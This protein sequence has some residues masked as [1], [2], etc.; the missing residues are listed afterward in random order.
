[1]PAYA[2]FHITIKDAGPYA[3]YA[4]HTPRVIAQYGGKMLVR[5]G[6]PEVVE[7][8]SPGQR[9]VVLE[10]A[11]R[12]AFKTFYNSPEYQKIIGIRQAVSEGVGMVVD[13]F[14]A[15]GWA[16]AVTESN[17]HG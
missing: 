9:V 10:F 14:P 13:G 6:D 1:M 11:D 5:G 8:K 4:K 12:A 17:K 15:E 16:A 2:I 3:D 7:G